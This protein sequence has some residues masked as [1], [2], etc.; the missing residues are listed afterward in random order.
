MENTAHPQLLELAFNFLGQQ[1]IASQHSMRRLAEGL[2][3]TGENL[4]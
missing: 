3:K 2:Y 1:G 4:L